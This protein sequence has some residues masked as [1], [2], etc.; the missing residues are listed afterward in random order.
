MSKVKEKRDNLSYVF[1]KYCATYSQGYTYEIMH[2]LLL[3][4]L[5]LTLL[6]SF[7]LQLYFKLQQGELI[8][9]KCYMIH[10]TQKHF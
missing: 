4:Q 8:H 9:I 10:Q 3:L 7:R 1:K 2:P 5:I 6:A